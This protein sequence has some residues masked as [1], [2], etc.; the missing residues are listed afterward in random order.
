M[1]TQIFLDGKLIDF[2]LIAYPI[3]V[4]KISNEVFFLTNKIL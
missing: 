1:S 4:V 3:K 2:L